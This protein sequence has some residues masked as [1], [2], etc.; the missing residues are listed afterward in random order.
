MCNAFTFYL[1]DGKRQFA[2]INIFNSEI[3]I[4]VGSSIK[5]KSSIEALIS[6]S[7]NGALPTDERRDSPGSLKEFSMPVRSNKNCTAAHHA[8]R[9]KVLVLFSLET[10]F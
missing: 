10:A 4:L 7:L 9:K 1:G 2:L 5:S 3:Y 6:S 8:H